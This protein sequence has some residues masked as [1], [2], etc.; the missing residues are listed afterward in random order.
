VNRLRFFFF[1]FS[2]FIFY[3][4]IFLNHFLINDMLTL[5]MTVPPVSE[6]PCNCF[7]SYDCSSVV[8]FFF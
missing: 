5:K 7:S 4:Y 3:I 8:S 6:E 2:V 1:F